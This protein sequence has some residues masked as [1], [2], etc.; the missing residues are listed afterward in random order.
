MG[1]KDFNF[2][3]NVDACPLSLD[4]RRSCSGIEFQDVGPVT[5]EAHPCVVA[6][7]HKGTFR[8]ELVEECSTRPEPTDDQ[9]HR[10]MNA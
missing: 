6:E 3:S 5:A 9:V 4:I 10:L 2:F 8:N 1:K 7:R